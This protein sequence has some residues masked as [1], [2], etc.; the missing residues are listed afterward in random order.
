ME[1][2]KLAFWVCLIISIGIITWRTVQKNEI[3]KEYLRKS[4]EVKKLEIELLN[5][6][7]NQTQNQLP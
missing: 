5:K 3:E 6:K 1:Y 7:L 2:L 4:I